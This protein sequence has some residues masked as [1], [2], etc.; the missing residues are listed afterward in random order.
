MRD[1]QPPFPSR[2]AQGRFPDADDGRRHPGKGAG[3]SRSPPALARLDPAPAAPLRAVDAASAVSTRTP[4]RGCR[5]ATW[6]A[7]RGAP[8]QAECGGAML[9]SVDDA[10]RGSAPRRAARPR[11]RRRAAAARLL[12]AVARH[13]SPPRRTIADHARHL[14]QQRRRRVA[15]VVVVFLEVIDVD[16]QQADIL[17]GRAARGHSDFSVWSYR[18]RLPTSVSASVVDRRVSSR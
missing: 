18:R 12:A 3:P 6:L 2:P 7:A 1:S 16:H 9:C 8:S 5:P 17:A 4:S 14:A 10:L 11:G 15:V 13:R